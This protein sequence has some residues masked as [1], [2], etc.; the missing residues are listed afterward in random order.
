MLNPILSHSS[1]S[2]LVAQWLARKIYNPED[3]G[4][5]PGRSA[6]K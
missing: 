3:A 5:T 6:T 1:Y 4:S 2:D